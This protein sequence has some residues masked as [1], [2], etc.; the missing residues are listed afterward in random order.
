MI[1]FF[2]INKTFSF[3]DIPGYG[4][5]K[6]PGAVK[7]KWGPMIET[8]LSTRDNLKGVVLI[9][10]IRRRP[11]P[12][13]LTLADWLNHYHIASIMV[14]TKTDKLSKSKQRIQMGLI[15]QALSVGRH[16]LILFSA[17]TRQGTQD[18]WRSIE[19]LLAEQKT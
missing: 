11:R 9:M 13:E 3:V 16:D 14:L 4:Y 2:V 10:D 8:Y 6:V 19:A 18:V 17:K 7:R 1:N 12:E 15:S 5:A